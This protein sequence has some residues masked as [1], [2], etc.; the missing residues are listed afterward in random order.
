M[1]V[2]HAVLGILASGPRHG[3][4][5]RRALEEELGAEWRVDFG[6]LYRVLARLDRAGWVRVQRQERAAGPTRKVRAI[7]AAGRRE[8]ERWRATPPP[9]TRRREATAVHRRLGGHAERPLLIAGSDDAVLDLLVSALAAQHPELGLDVERVGS[10]AGLWALREGRAQIAG[11]HLLDADSREY[12]V[13]FVKHLL[14]EES[15]LLLTLARREQGLLLAPGNPCRVRG[16]CDLARRGVR[17]VNRQRGAGTRLLLHH[18]LR[19]ARLDPAALPGWERAVATHAAVAAAIAAG[20]ADAGPGTR[21]A[22]AQAGLDFLPIGEER[23][24]LAIPRALFDAPRLRPL[25]EA[26]HARAFR[27]AA[28]ALPGYDLT[29]MGAVAAR[30]ND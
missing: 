14:P 3:Y 27:R 15:V 28:A 23:Y 13:P 22:A 30:I 29:R 6:Q 24:D 11:I 21:A 1:P 17:L 18:A 16:V 26:L 19:A 9:A 8:L 10:L 20:E 4:D 5:L 12:N 2:A 7:T 25:F